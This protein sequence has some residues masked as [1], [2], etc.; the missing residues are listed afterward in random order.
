M[1]RFFVSTVL[2]CVL[3][4]PALA[5]NAAPASQQIG[6]GTTGSLNPN[7][8]KKMPAKPNKIL[9]NALTPKTRAMLQ[10]AMDANPDG[11]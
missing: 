10:Q 11:K 2:A 5:Q 4:L 7:G 3:M 8:H 9:N 6:P 1:N